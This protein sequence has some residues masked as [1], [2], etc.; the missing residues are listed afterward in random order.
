MKERASERERVREGWG[1]REREP[2]RGRPSTYSVRAW[3]CGAC[4]AKMLNHLDFS[5]AYTIS[6]P[7]IEYTTTQLVPLILLLL[8]LFISYFSTH[9]IH[10]HILF[11]HKYTHT[12]TRESLYEH[13]IISCYIQCHKQL[14][15]RMREDHS[16]SPSHRAE[17]SRAEY[18]SHH[19]NRLL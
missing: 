13:T 14:K 12:Y 5:F 9:Y 18:L 6:H 7:H 17:L 8:S 15:W 4:M 1:G 10:T 16:Q 11:I 2:E 3:M 19:S